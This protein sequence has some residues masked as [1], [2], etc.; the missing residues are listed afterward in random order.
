MLTISTG[1]FT[2]LTNNLNSPLKLC[3]SAYKNVSTINSITKYF[4]KFECEQ[5]LKL[6]RSYYLR[7]ST[8]KLPQELYCGIDSEANKIAEAI[9]RHR[10]RNVPLI[11]VYPGPG[12]I[13][14]Y[15]VNGNDGRLLLFDSNNNFLDASQVF[16]QTPNSNWK[17]IIIFGVCLVFDDA[18]KRRKPKL[19]WSTIVGF[20]ALWHQPELHTT[21][22]NK[23][24]GR[25]YHCSSNHHIYVVCIHQRYL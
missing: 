13:T 23:Q 1:A 22:C 24:M 11:E 10:N 7:R 19:S 4:G 21:I 12:V 14:K 2:K 9:G 17:F 6:F 16:F 3:G 5:N 20:L 18:A 25:W 8:K 15:L